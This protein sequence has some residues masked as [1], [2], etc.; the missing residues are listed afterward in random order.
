LCR[1]S[2]YINRSATSY[3]ADKI[4]RSSGI[5][6]DFGARMFAFVQ[7]PDFLKS[8]LQTYGGRNGQFSA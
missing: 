5:Q 1:G 8:V 3:L 6:Q 2:K 7:L 4:T